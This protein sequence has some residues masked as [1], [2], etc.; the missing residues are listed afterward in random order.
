MKNKSLETRIADDLLNFLKSR[1]TLH[2][3]TLD[4]NNHPY[5]SYAPYAIGDDCFYVLLS[6]I[7]LHGINLKNNGKA[8]ILIVED[9]DQAQ[10]IFARVRV[11]YQV[12]AQLINIED[13]EQYDQAIDCLYQK[14][15][16]RIHSLR[17]LTDFNLFKLTP[18]GG[19]FVRDFGKAYAIEGHSLT[20]ENINHLRDGHKPRVESLA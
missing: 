7:A 10:T 11:N 5:S 3:S 15:G 13:G 14:Q 2:L 9:E 20:G 16:E 18:V 8:G 19:R 4:A 17:Q 12:N 1:R 6:D